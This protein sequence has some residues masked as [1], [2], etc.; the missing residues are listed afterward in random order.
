[1][2]LLVNIKSTGSIN[3][4]G[5]YRAVYKEIGKQ[6]VI[7]VILESHSHLYD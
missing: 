2:H 6:E 5:D 3:I 4:T 7:F 1:M